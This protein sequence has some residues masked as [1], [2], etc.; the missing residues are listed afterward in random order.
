MKLTTILLSLMFAASPVFAAKANGPKAT[1][2]KA[3]KAENPKASKAE[4]KKCVS[5][6]L[7]A[8]K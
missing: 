1:A 3:C 5:T 6:K 8:A 7:K 4:L 2:H